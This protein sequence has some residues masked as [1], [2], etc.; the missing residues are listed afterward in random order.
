MYKIKSTEQRQEKASEFETRSLFYLMNYSV[1]K[2]NIEYF[3]IDLFNDVTGVNK[4][5][6]SCFDVQSKG[7][8]SMAPSQIGCALVTLFKN[9]LS[10]FN[11]VSYYLYMES[12]SPVVVAAIKGKTVFKYSDFS[13]SIKDS[14]FLSLKN[15]C[16]DKE[17]IDF[18]LVT[19]EKLKN[20]LGL[21]TFVINSKSISELVLDAVECKLTMIEEEKLKSIFK[22]IRDKQSSKK[23]T[24]TE[25]CILSVIGDFKPFEKHILADDIKSLIINRICFNNFLERPV[26]INKFFI[27]FYEKYCLSFD[28][29]E[30]CSSKILL[31]M[32]NKNNI[33]AFWDLFNEAIIKIKSNENAE[34]EDICNL[35]NNNLFDRTL[36]LK[37]LKHKVFL[38]SLLMEVLIC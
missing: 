30:D 28:D 23:L 27:S 6:D 32:S 34:A 8:K 2:N 35:I 10:E 26:Q 36:F 31:L 14:I 18:A 29:V 22:E 5:C 11:F 24:N 38:I 37:E 7:V 17:Y 12:F 15:E 3:V 20:F 25:N 33:N 21:V 19:D 4:N 9:F 16:K 1:D 13:D